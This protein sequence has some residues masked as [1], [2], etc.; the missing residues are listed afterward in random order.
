M[1]KF[2]IINYHSLKKRNGIQHNKLAT[3]CNQKLIHNSNTVSKF[4][5]NTNN[6]NK[7]NMLH[8]IS[9]MYIEMMY[10]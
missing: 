8:Y 3:L 2:I 4:P 10:V 5:Q 1:Y 9:T 7:D 6:N